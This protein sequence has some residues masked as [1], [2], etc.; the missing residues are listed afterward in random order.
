MQTTRELLVYLPEEEQEQ[1]LRISRTA[2]AN[3]RREKLDLRADMDVI[4]EE[5]IR[6]LIRDDDVLPGSELPAG[7]PA[8]LL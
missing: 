6:R 3:W 4:L 2:S 7:C 1:M 5:E 8:R